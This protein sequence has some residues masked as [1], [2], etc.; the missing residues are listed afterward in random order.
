MQ[1]RIDWNYEYSYSSSIA[2]TQQGLRRP[3][4]GPLLFNNQMNAEL[5]DA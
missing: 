4:T 1:N 5:A 2:V 3:S